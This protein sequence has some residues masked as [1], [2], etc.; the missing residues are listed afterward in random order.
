MHYQKSKKILIYIFLFLI[1]GT[2]NNKNLNNIKMPNIEK[3]TVEGLDD[4]NNKELTNNLNFLRINNLFFLDKIYISKIISSNN[5]VEEYSIFK[6]YPSSLYIKIIK[7]KF[8]AQIKRNDHFLLLGSN[9]KF[10]KIKNIKSEVPFIFGDFD[11]KNFFNLL[12]AI[13]KTKFN[14]G[15]IKNLFFFKSGRWDI[16]T[17]SGILIKLPKNNIKKSLEIYLSILNKG[18]HKKIKKIDL[19][20][21][22]QIIIDGK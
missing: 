4:R 13:D 7:T 19:R 12:D 15:E 8:L 22:N 11:N 17:N 18:D 16:E 6:K 9:G 3:I 20:Q 1:I 5:L 10:T 21:R 2:L 14:Y